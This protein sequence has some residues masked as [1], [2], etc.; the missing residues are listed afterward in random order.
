[1]PS[2]CSDYVQTV[3][4][5]AWPHVQ[6]LIAA[7]RLLWWTLA[8]A[9][10]PMLLVVPGFVLTLADPTATIGVIAGIAATMLAL[11]AAW[12]W[13]VA[14]FLVRGNERWLYRAAGV[15]TPVWLAGNVVVASMTAVPLWAIWLSALVVAVGAADAPDAQ[16]HWWRLAVLFAI[17][18]I[19]QC[20]GTVVV[21]WYR[22]P[23]QRAFPFV[24]GRG[25]LTG[26]VVLLA[27]ILAIDDERSRIGFYAAVA[28][29]WTLANLLLV[30]W[31]RFLATWTTDYGRFLDAAC[32]SQRARRLLARP[33]VIVAVST[34]ATFAFI[35]LAGSHELLAVVVAVVQPVLAALLGARRCHGASDV[36]VL[37]VCATS[38]ITVAY[39]A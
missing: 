33:F 17:G 26:H 27:A 22:M 8:A 12:P 11:H 31:L 20:A 38:C 21:S 3:A 4:G 30:R 6:A 24:L 39:A 7:D 18:Q 14:R 23:W 13:V 1:M 15:G 9:A 10:A 36:Y 5:L 19:A 32:G 29:C 35:A 2:G 37:A 28:A 34:Y 25:Y 16:W